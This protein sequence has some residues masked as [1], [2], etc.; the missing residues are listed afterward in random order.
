MTTTLFTDGWTF[1]RD[2]VDA[3]IPVRLPHDAM[4]GE[5]RSADAGTDNHGGFF[6]GGAYVYRKRWTA[7]DDAGKR[8]QR[9]TFE[10]VYGATRVFM[11]GREIGRNDSPYREFSVPLDVVTPGEALTIE[12]YVDNRHVPNSRWYT[13]SGIYRPV[14][15]ESD[16][17]VHIAPDG[18]RIVTR[19]VDQGRQR[20]DA[21]VDVETRIDGP[22]PASAEVFVAFELDGKVEASGAASVS[23]GVANVSIPIADARLWSAEHPHLYDVRVSVLFDAQTLDE[24]HRRTGLRTIEVDARQGLRINHEQVLLRGTAVHHDN[25]LLGAATWTDAERRRARLL[26]EAGYNAIRSAHNPLSRA[27]LDACDEFG[28]YVMDELTDVWFAHKTSHD[29]AEHFRDE[30]RADAA[31]MIATDRNRPSVIMYSIGNEI[32]E[33]ATGPGV[34]L[35]LE[36]QAYFTEVDPTRHTTIAVNPLLAMMAA[37]AKPAE[38]GDATPPE[39]TPATSTAANLMTAKL[40]RMMVLASMLPAADNASRDIFA[41]VDIAGYNYGYASYRRARKRYPDRVIV[42]TESMP[43]DLP[44]IW[45]RVTSIPGVIGDFSWTGWDYLGEVGLGY[46]SYGKEPGGIAKPYPGV[47]AGCGVFDITGASAATLLLAQA[48]WGITDAPGIAVRP[49]DKAGQRP[50]KTPW[51]STDAVTSWSWRGLTG[52]ADIEVYSAEDQV[53][54]I[55]NGRSLGRRASGPKRGFVARFHTP[56]EPGELVAIAYRQGV[57]TGRSSLRSAGEPRLRLRAETE[58]LT[59]PDSLSYVWVELADG[60]GVVDAASVDHV[61]VTVSGPGV[62]AALGSA[63]PS[64]EESFVDTERTTYRG[65]ALAIVRGTGLDGEIVLNVTSQRHGD[66]TLTLDGTALHVPGLTPASTTSPRNAS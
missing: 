38:G 46:W 66:A 58:Q 48:V 59:G 64:T 47:L 36:I 6:A 31:A 56:Y 52:R 10:G 2:G 60:D 20:S 26:K 43:G 61:S 33:S 8:S 7:P 30:W 57:E 42:G 24:R 15:L 17:A 53:E 54:L 28:L 35:A 9:L 13:G 63:A 65:R 51:L 49:V 25:G 37:K 12:V 40:G 16:G 55:L 45:K 62:L 11:N 19:T 34:D 22:V 27:F 21:V 4:I 23:K 14:W 32:A 29:R 3:G 41:S 5:P 18:V 1:H 39:R 44:A 50:N